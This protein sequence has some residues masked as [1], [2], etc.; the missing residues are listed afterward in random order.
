M[1]EEGSVCCRKWIWFLPPSIAHSLLL[2]IY[3]YKIFFFCMNVCVCVPLPSSVIF[4]GHP[5]ILH[6]EWILRVI[7]T[8]YPKSS[9]TDQIWSYLAFR[10]DSM[11]LI[12]KEKLSIEFKSKWASRDGTVTSRGREGIA[13]GLIRIAGFC[14][15]L[16]M[17]SVHVGG[18]WVD[19]VFDVNRLLAR[20]YIYRSLGD[21]DY[22]F[23]HPLLEEGCFFWV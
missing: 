14:Y 8:F 12:V 7:S 23:I 15:R 20:N 4:L 17:F 1:A 19:V 9:Q 3:I 22:L 21:A 10:F 18:C 6:Q 13:V 16:E 2:Y 5:A 11:L